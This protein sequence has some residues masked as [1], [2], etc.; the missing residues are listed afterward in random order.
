MPGVRL[1]LSSL[2][3]TKEDAFMAPN[4][5]RLKEL[6]VKELRREQSELEEEIQS[7]T[8]STK[9]KASV[10][11]SSRKPLTKAQRT[12]HSDRMKA[13]WAK[14]KSGKK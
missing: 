10:K 4:E 3:P 1:T 2:N 13:I 11:K 8:A 12:A 7:L 9:K 14:K 5:S 6:A